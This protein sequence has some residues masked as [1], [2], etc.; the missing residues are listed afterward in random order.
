M[1]CQ[2]A[3]LKIFNPKIVSFKLIKFNDLKE[4]I[5]NDC[6]FVDKVTFKEKIN[7]AVKERKQMNSEVKIVYVLWRANKVCGSGLR[8]SKLRSI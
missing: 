8:I 5:S 6:V 1:S 4:K 3:L 2:S 7:D